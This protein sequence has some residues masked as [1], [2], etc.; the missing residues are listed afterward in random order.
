MKSIN[1]AYPSSSDAVRFRFAKTGCYTVAVNNKTLTAFATYKDAK[2]HAD[3]LPDDYSIF[4]MDGQGSC[5]ALDA[6]RAGR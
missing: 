5:T 6:V 1:Y 3:L 2:Q 4:S